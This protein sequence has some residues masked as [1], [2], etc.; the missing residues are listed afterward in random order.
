[1]KDHLSAGYCIEKEQ[2]NMAGYL[3]RQGIV[4][5]LPV[6]ISLTTL[7]ISLPRLCRCVTNT[8]FLLTS[9]ADKEDLGLLR[10]TPPYFVIEIVLSSFLSF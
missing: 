3:I 2:S 5:G 4:L 9:Q 10:K 8:S 7:L 1:M 6:L